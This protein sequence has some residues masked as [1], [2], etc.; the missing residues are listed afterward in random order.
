MPA[1][2]RK[3]DS[4]IAPDKGL[5]NIS[6]WHQRMEKNRKVAVYR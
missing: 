4:P 3:S 1:F 2:A 5:I 6:K